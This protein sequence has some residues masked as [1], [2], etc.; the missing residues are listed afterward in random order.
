MHNAEANA[1]RELRQLN[2]N[3][4]LGT[5]T[6]CCVWGEHKLNIV[7][8]CAAT[9]VVWNVIQFLMNLFMYTILVL[10][11]PVIVVTAA[12]YIVVYP[13]TTAIIVYVFEGIAI[14]VYMI[15]WCIKRWSNVKSEHQ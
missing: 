12:A 1:Y 14:L 10:Y 2:W 8:C 7:K 15:W 5:R 4:E 6:K 11:A 9:K 13:D 3:K